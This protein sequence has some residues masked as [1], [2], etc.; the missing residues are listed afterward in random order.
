VTD[1]DWSK[2]MHAPADDW[3]CPVVRPRLKLQFERGEAELTKL[4]L[5][6]VAETQMRFAQAELVERET[7]EE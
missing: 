1:K 4:M 2:L 3:P 5:Q 7:V 6:T